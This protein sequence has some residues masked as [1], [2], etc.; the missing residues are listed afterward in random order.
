MS[1]DESSNTDD[2][3]S[4]L[5]KKR[6]TIETEKNI[7]QN[8][9]RFGTVLRKSLQIICKMMRMH[10]KVL[11]QMKLIFICK[12]FVSIAKTCLIRTKFAKIHLSPL[13][14]N[15]VSAIVCYQQMLEKLFSII[16]I[17]H[18]LILNLKVMLCY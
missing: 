14:S 2:N 16:T 9:D 18:G 10:R 4:P 11:S 8:H 17:H 13:G 7:S 12:L 6:N 3:S 5:C 15:A 1:C